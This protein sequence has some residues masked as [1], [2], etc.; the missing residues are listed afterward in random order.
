MLNDVMRNN[1]CHTD[2]KKC[3]ITLELFA[4]VL[5]IAHGLFNTLPYDA[6]NSCIQ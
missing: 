5:I 3:L 2:V 4:S 6:D 1:S